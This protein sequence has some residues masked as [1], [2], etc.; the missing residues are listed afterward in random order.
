MNPKKSLKEQGINEAEALTLTLRKRLFFTETTCCS[1]DSR[2]EKE[3][4]L[5]YL[6]LQN[7]LISEFYGCT[8]SCDKAIKLAALQCCIEDENNIDEDFLDH[9]LNSLLPCKYAK[10]QGITSTISEAYNS[11]DRELRESSNKAK[12]EYIRLCTTLDGFGITLFSGKV[13]IFEL[14]HMYAYTLIITTT[15]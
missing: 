7:A 6:E 13:G 15:F 5:T 4:N 10:V 2:D 8:I 12:S 3:L 14:Y 9:K 1:C 11:L